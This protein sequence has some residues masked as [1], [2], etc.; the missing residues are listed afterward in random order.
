[1]VVVNQ[2]LDPEEHRSLIAKFKREHEKRVAYERSLD[3][4]AERQKKKLKNLN[5]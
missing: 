2:N 3:D 1:M 5:I 4:E